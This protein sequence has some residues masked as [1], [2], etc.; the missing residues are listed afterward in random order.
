MKYLRVAPKFVQNSFYE[1]EWRIYLSAK[2]LT[3]YSAKVSQT[4]LFSMR[5]QFKNADKFIIVF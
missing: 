3:H 5:I 4:L 2:L 1:T